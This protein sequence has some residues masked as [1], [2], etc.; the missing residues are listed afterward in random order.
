MGQLARS[1]E[2]HTHVDP[3][4]AHCKVANTISSYLFTL[5]K[6]TV[7]ADVALFRLPSLSMVQI[8]YFK[9]RY[10]LVYANSYLALAV[11]GT[12]STTTPSAGNTYRKD[13][14]M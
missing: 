4:I 7:V 5:Y 3:R 10:F 14:A 2:A 11:R 12:D 1:K 9:N 13:A 8:D 6:P